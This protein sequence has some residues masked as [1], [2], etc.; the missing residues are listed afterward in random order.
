MKDLMTAIPE[1][2]VSLD[3]NGHPVF[4]LRQ[5]HVPEDLRAQILAVFEKNPT[6]GS[7]SFAGEFRKIHGSNLKRKD[8]GYKSLKHL[9]ATI[10][11]ITVTTRSGGQPIFTLS[12]AQPSAAEQPT[13]TRSKES[14]KEPRELGKPDKKERSVASQQRV[15]SLSFV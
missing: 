3:S 9:M 11:E 12:S 8:H 14:D 2:A 6:I 13:A 15:R 7:E 1:I 4:A 10:P 5:K